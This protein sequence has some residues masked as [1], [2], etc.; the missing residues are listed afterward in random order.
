MRQHESV[1]RL[2]R[3]GGDL[4]SHGVGIRNRSNAGGA[5]LQKLGTENLG[6][7]ITPPEQADEGRIEMRWQFFALDQAGEA[8]FHFD[9]LFVVNG[10]ITPQANDPEDFFILALQNA[11]L[12]EVV[13]CRLFDVAFLIGESQKPIGNGMTFFGGG[14]ALEPGIEQGISRR[15]GVE[16]FDALGSRRRSDSRCWRFSAKRLERSMSSLNSN[17]ITPTIPR[18]NKL[19]MIGTSIIPQ[20]TSIV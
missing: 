13:E 18:K 20:R 17:A 10:G 3:G 5:S 16:D 8:R 9:P 6:D 2:A 11:S 7:Q 1:D 4:A 15:G 12:D 14:Y 19:A